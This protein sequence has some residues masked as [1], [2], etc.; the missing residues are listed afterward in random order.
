MLKMLYL[1]GNQLTQ[2]PASL[3]PSLT[4]L[5]LQNNR[6]T[7]IK[8]VDLINLINLRV[9]DVSGNKIIY[10]PQLSLPALITLSVK[11][12]GLEN[13]H[14]HISRTCPKLRHLVINGNPI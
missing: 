6:I 1:E 10:I 7:D 2:I 9:L 4:R 5:N 11:S 12:C 13:I 8:V 14:R 3:P